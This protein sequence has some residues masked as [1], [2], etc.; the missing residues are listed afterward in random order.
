MNTMPIQHAPAP[1]PKKGGLP[2]GCV[3]ALAVIGGLIVAGGLAMAIGIYVFANSETG[4]KI[5][6]V[7]RK[8]VQR[9]ERGERE[10]PP[11]VAAAVRVLCPATE[12]DTDSPVGASER[13]F[14]PTICPSGDTNGTETPFRY[15][16]SER[17]F[18]P[19]VSPPG[20]T[21]P[22]DD[23]EPLPSPTRRTVADEH[24]E[25]GWAWLRVDSQRW[26]S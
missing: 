16:S 22:V 4:K 6:G 14:G 11:D 5:A 9:Y 15:S 13:G 1:S 25:D 23:D 24:D 26:D 19:T 10:V 20:D 18:G 3:V 21:L 12:T 7:A 2:K 17:G 8:T